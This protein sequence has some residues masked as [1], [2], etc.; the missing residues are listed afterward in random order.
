MFY[1]DMNQIRCRLNRLGVILNEGTDYARR[2][3]PATLADFKREH[4]E[5]I[6]IYG[7]PDRL[8]DGVF[9][10]EAGRGGLNP[11]RP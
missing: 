1:H 11:C 8:K 3:L 7:K 5:L 10:A 4:D 6:G 9:I 2:P